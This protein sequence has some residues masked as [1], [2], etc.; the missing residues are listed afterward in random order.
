[1]RLLFRF[2]AAVLKQLRVVDT[3]Q[4]LDECDRAVLLELDHLCEED[5][6][7]RKGGGA[8]EFERVGGE[9]VGCQ[10]EIR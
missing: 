1:M 3:R 5:W 6:G 10:I 9:G 4:E 2:V 7:G 8:T